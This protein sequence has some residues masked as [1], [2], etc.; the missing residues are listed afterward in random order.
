MY[1]INAKNSKPESL[2]KPPVA[3]P[4]S[5]VA[6]PPEDLRTGKGK[7]DEKKEVQGKF[8]DESILQDSTNK[9]A[10]KIATELSGIIQKDYM[11]LIK[12]GA[13][14]QSMEREYRGSVEAMGY[15]WEDFVTVTLE[16]GYQ[17]LLDDYIRRQNMIT[18]EDVVA[19]K[20]AGKLATTDY[21]EES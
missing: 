5:R 7:N 17:I 3:E 11:E 10:G 14:L 16:Y 6:P 20:M 13:A 18:I 9:A 8:T 4:R 12:S 15:E 1:E 2:N 21:T 19:M